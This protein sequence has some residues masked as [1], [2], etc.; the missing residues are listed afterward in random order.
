MLLA[1]P[2]RAELNASVILEQVGP[3]KSF[4][5]AFSSNA[6]SIA[7]SCGLDKVTKLE[8]S[9]R[10]KIT[11]TRPL[12][13]LPMSVAA[14]QKMDSCKLSAG[15]ALLSSGASSRNCHDCWSSG[16]EAFFRVS[17]GCPLSV[18]A[19]TSWTRPV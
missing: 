10:F 8:K 17:P 5:T 7:A 1:P 15:A 4:Q 19:R 18:K 9:R 13:G 16:G 11:A 12:T 2:S 3:R 6:V 14:L